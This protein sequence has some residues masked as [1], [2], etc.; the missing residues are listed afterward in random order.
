MR[1]GIIGAGNIGAT[2][3]G[4]LVALGHDVVMANSRGPESLMAIAAE[5]GAT[6]AP[7]S[8]AADKADIV[9]IAIPQ[10][11]VLDLPRDLFAA[12]AKDCI[13]IDT[14]NYYPEW[15]DGRIEAIENG[16]VESR[17]V[18]QQIGRPVIKIFNSILAN[19]LANEGCQPGAPG[20]IALPVAGD[21]AQ[22]K[23][24]VIALVDKLGFDGI[25]AGCLDESWR[26]QPGT[27]SYCT[28][29][30][31]DDLREAL[32]RADRSQAPALRDRGFQQMLQLP[33]GFS[34]PILVET[35]RALFR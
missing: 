7:V 33:K 25:D 32:K 1:I 8:R 17:W 6:A 34:P 13:V 26:Q 22:A 20:R 9:I 12:T 14:G 28:D 4:K 19:S 21:D 15:R 3:A 11:A 16:M 30:G 35:L 10:K 24:I 27:A 23:A 5:T 31:S 18:S 2:L 29:L